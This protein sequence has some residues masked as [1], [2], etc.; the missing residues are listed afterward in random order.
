MPGLKDYRKN[1][2]RAIKALD[3]CRI[4]RC[5]KCPLHLKGCKDKLMLESA[6]ILSDYLKNLSQFEEMSRK[7]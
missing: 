3:C 7:S 5:A 4:S 1:I 2:R 6:E